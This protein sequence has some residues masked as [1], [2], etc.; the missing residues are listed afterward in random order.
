LFDLK[1]KRIVE[2]VEENEELKQELAHSQK[3]I[4]ESLVEVDHLYSQVWTIISDA[5]TTNTSK[6][7]TSLDEETKKAL[8]KSVETQAISNHASE[9]NIED[10]QLSLVRFKIENESL[11]RQLEHERM[12]VEELE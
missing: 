9:E 8:H 2:L 10:G 1:H 12:K 4:E 7:K 6:S 5:F 3:T 11:Q